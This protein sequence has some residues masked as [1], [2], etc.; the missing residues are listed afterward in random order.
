MKTDAYQKLHDDCDAFLKAGQIGKAVHALH[1][2]NSAKVPRALR[3]PLARICRRCGL[4]AEGLRLLMPVVRSERGSE[5]TP[6]EQAEYAILLV[7]NGAVREAQ[8]LLA[9]NP[10][11]ESSLFRA[12]AH[13]AQWEYEAAIPHLQNYLTQ[14]VGDYQAL[15]G[16]VNLGAALVATDRADEG[17]VL[18]CENIDIAL[19]GGHGR[20]AGNC[21]ELRSQIHLKRGDFA[22]AL[23]DLRE[24]EL[25]LGGNDL[26]FVRKWRAV[27]EA[28]DTRSPQPLRA[29]R[30]E[31][32][33]RREWENLRDIDSQTLRLGFDQKLFDHLYFGTPFAAFRANLCTEFN[34][35]PSAGEYI[36]GEGP[37]RLDLYSDPKMKT[38]QKLVEILL[39]DFYRP[40]SLGNLFAELFPGEYFDIF[41]SPDRVHQVLRRARAWISGEKLDLSVAHEGGRF[42]A[43]PGAGLTIV[44]PRERTG[45]DPV[46]RRLR[47]LRSALGASPYFSASEAERHLD[48]SRPALNRLLSR[49]VE[50]GQLRRFGAT[51]AIRYYFSE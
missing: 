49:G 43:V 11:P 40:F 25:K 6:G 38:P 33:E 32:L 13:F 36:L 21:L 35:R 3:L 39:R 22:A 18:L 16:R 14:P 10:A 50:S 24:A 17:L 42:R 37:R 26:F 2:L 27:A 47:D 46:E 8:T 20:L 29:I 23:A 9:R 51:R 19:R 15:V 4:V 45:L 44:L 34:A 48:L 7:R 5:G 1:G 31:A 28:M 12:F 30:A 41:T